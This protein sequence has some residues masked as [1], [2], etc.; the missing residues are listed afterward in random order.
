MEILSCWI[1]TSWNWLQLS[2]RISEWENMV[3]EQ[4]W[5]FWCSFSM[6]R[7]LCWSLPCPFCASNTRCIQSN[8]GSNYSSSSPSFSSLKRVCVFFFLFIKLLRGI[9]FPFKK[10]TVIL[11]HAMATSHGM[12]DLINNSPIRDRTLAPAVDAPS[13]NHWTTREVLAFVSFSLSNCNYIFKVTKQCFKNDLTEVSNFDS[14]SLHPFWYM[15]ASSCSF[16]HHICGS[17]NTFLPAVSILITVRLKLWVCL[18]TRNGAR[19]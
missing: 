4:G 5:I 19:F 11:S 3:L 16:N 6:C 7:V 18:N 2:W 10:C 15:L 17:E 13:L 9:C 8:I 14:K 12:L 1:I